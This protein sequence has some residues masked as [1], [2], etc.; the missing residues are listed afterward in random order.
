MTIIGNAFDTASS[1]SEGI[2]LREGTKAQLHNFVVTNAAGECFEI[3]GGAT[4]SVTVNQALSGD[5][6]IS[7]S[8]FA[9]TENFKNAK[10]DDGT[11]LLDTQDWVLNQNT[12]NTTATGINDVVNGIFTIDATTPKDFS[13]STFFDNANHIGAV[14]ESNN[15]T[16]GW[17]VGLE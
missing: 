13:G 4:S 6:V 14:S 12:A 3:E 15:W 16:A 9:C 10:A 2:Y 1:D 11:I 5:T 17:T 7:N 8:V